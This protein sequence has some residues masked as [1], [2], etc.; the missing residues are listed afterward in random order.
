MPAASWSSLLAVLSDRIEK[1]EADLF[2]LICSAF[3]ILNWDFLGSPS[4]PL[5]LCRLNDL[6]RLV[7]T[8]CSSSKPFPS[9]SSSLASSYWMFR[10]SCWFSLMANRKFS[11]SS[12]K[13]LW[14]AWD[15]SA[16]PESVMIL[17]LSLS[18]NCIRAV[19]FCPMT[20]SL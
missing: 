7:S 17:H 13:L 16:S 5:E 11:W 12:L 6:T 10:F 18:N 1:W 3:P 4:R 8:S 20:L 14:M 19:S 9:A 2:S 15:L